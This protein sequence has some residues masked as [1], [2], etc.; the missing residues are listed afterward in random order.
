MIFKVHS[1]QKGQ[2]RTA[3]DDPGRFH[4]GWRVTKCSKKE[5]GVL[6]DRRTSFEE[7]STGQ[8]YRK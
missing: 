1:P 6:K 8:I 4:A 5:G 3:Q 2:A 7:A